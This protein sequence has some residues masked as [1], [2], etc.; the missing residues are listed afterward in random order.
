MRKEAK[1]SKELKRNMMSRMIRILPYHQIR[2]ICN[3]KGGK[4]GNKNQLKHFQIE[5]FNF[6]TVQSFTYL[7]SLKKLK[8]RKEFYWPIKAFMD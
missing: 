7:G 6:E 1:N 2:I 5:N 8:L 3:F 4:L